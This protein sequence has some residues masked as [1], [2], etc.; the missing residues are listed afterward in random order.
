MTRQF[1]RIRYGNFD[2]TP[3]IYEEMADGYLLLANSQQPSAN[4]LKKGGDV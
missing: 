3:E 2:A 4:T 1:L